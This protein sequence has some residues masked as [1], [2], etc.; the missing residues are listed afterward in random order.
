MADPLRTYHPQFVSSARLPVAIGR[1]RASSRSCCDAPAR[2]AVLAAGQ[3][4]TIT[5]SMAGQI[6]MGGFTRLR[7]PL[8]K[9]RI[10]SRVLA[11]VPAAIIAS[12]FGSHGA[13]ALLIFSQVVLSIQLPFA[14]I[15]LVR[16][17][18]DR[19]LMGEFASGPWMRIVVSA[20]VAFVV[21]LNIKLVRDLF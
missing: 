17:C 3:N 19:T 14:A 8:W 5:R 12:L 18:E 10:L 2:L 16:M 7:M 20:C 9:R 21:T 6:V 4:A 11:L 15:P 1:K 13:S